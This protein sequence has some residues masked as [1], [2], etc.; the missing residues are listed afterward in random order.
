MLWLRRRKERRGKECPLS[1]I[2]YL[3]CAQ[4]GAKAFSHYSYNNWRGGPSYLH[5]SDEEA[6]AQKSCFPYQKLLS[7]TIVGGPSNFNYFEVSQKSSCYEV[8]SKSE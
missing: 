5:S 4:S 2:E 7:S 6:K 8:S 3:L 1:F